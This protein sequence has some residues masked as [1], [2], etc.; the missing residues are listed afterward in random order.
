MS[1]WIELL[2]A[3]TLLPLTES[4]SFSKYMIWISEASSATKS[5]PEPEQVIIVTP[6]PVTAALNMRLIPE[7]C[8]VKRTS[9]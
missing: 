2:K 9:P 1:H 5:S 8:F 4:E 6:S 7:L 3:R